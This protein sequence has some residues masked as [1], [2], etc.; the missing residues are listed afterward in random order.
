MLNDRELTALLKEGR[1]SKIQVNGIYYQLN[2]CEAFRQNRNGCSGIAG[3]VL[4]FALDVE[5]VPE[6]AVCSLSFSA[7][8]EAELGCRILP[9]Y[10]GHG[11]GTEAF[12]RTAEWALYALGLRKV[13]AKCYHENAASWRMLS[14]CMRPSGEDEWF[15]YFEKTV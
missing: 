15:Y 14:S 4:E 9:E 8:G 6:G 5:E 10:S 13:L 11:Y 1:I 2:E 7:R 3:G 12:A